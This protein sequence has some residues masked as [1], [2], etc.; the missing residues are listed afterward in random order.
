[1]IETGRLI[2]NLENVNYISFLNDTIPLY[3]ELA[4]N[5]GIRI[6]LLP[7]EKY[8][9]LS[10]DRIKI[11]QVITNFI[12]NA[13]K[14]SNSNT[15]VKIEV[16][17]EGDYV[18]TKIIDEGEGIPLSQRELLFKMF[19]KTASLP[20][21]GEKGSGLG[22]YISKRI[23]E[24]HDGVIGFQGNETTGSTFYFKLKR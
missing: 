24:A 17:V 10:I 11:S 4:K 15:T 9:Q 16:E 23:I 2:L 12:H 13:I 7:E 21:A 8:I 14:F 1:V 19:S 18:V 20:T 3:M 5:K 22:L 6:L